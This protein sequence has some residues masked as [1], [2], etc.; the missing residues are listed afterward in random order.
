MPQLTN[1]RSTNDFIP[2]NKSTVYQIH[3]RQTVESAG[4]CNKG[5]LNNRLRA[6]TAEQTT[7]DKWTKNKCNVDAIG[8]TNDFM[9]FQHTARADRT[10]SRCTIASMNKEQMAHATNGF[11]TEDK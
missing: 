4:L 7:N 5:H 9:T 10:K 2:K 3:E 6:K 11:A 8:G 1:A